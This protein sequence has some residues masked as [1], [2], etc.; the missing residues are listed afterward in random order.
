[1][2]PG[3]W[4]SPSTPAAATSRAPG[5]QAAPT[6]ISSPSAFSRVS[7][8]TAFSSS[9]TPS[10]PA[11]SSRCVSCPK[12]G[13]WCSGWSAPSFRSSRKR[14]T[15]GAAS[16]PRPGT[17]RWKTS[18]SARSAGFRARTTATTSPSSRKS[19][20]S[21]FASTSPERYGASLH[22]GHFD[23][24]SARLQARLPAEQDVRVALFACE[25]GRVQA[26]RR[27]LHD[28]LFTFRSREAADPLARLRRHDRRRHEYLL[29]AEDRLGHPQQPLSHGRAVAGGER[30]WGVLR[31]P[32]RIADLRARIRS[33]GVPGAER[34]AR[35][36][37]ADEPVLRARQGRLAGRRRAAAGQCH[38]APAAHRAPLLQ[39]R[40]IPPQSRFFLPRGPACGG[41]GHRGHVAPAAGKALRLHERVLRSDVPGSDRI[42]SQPIGQPH[43][44][45]NHGA[46]RR[47][48][49]R[50][51][52]VA[53][54]ARG[55]LTAGA[56]RPPALLRADD[57]RH[58]PDYFSRR[59]EGPLTAKAVI[60]FKW[61][62]SYPIIGL[63]TYLALTEPLPE[64]QT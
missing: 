56:P 52:H 61:I 39:A 37:G 20:S 5:S 33:H 2:C 29:H 9:T 3:T 38:P 40:S 49:G 12:A 4:R 28:P 16:T 63:R 17:C 10:A 13:K 19:R 57:H 51:H 24:R 64:K 48:S 21:S 15:S 41:T 43:P 47:R 8:S 60:Q 35:L 14:T 32:L 1:M 31:A 7:T 58:G 11:A 26:R 59:L 44:P 50:A 27:G 18:P 53:G 45:A 46:G 54:N 62:T 22:C 6:P 25:P 42:R 36:P 34:R 55:A 30:Q 23:L